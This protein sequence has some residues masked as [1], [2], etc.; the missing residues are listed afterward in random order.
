MHEISS[1]VSI[2]IL[3][4]LKLNILHVNSTMPWLCRQSIPNFI[5]CTRLPK[6]FRLPHP[7][8]TKAYALSIDKMIE[9]QCHTLTMAFVNFPFSARPP[10]IIELFFNLFHI[11]GYLSWLCSV[12]FLFSGYWAQDKYDVICMYTQDYRNVQGFD[13]SVKQWGEESKELYKKHIKSGY[14]VR[15]YYWIMYE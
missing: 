7:K 6:R 10:F 2:S 5:T 13:L 9:E 4:C 8:K 1:S 3:K 12:P 15:K 14:Q 11:S